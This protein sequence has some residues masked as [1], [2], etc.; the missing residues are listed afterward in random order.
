MSARCRTSSA[1]FTVLEIIVSMILLGVVL[2][3]VA[4]LTKRV[5]DQRRA[6]EARR[7]ALFEVSNDLERLVADRSAWP[8]AGEQ[9]S[10]D[11]SA[12]LRTRFH[13]PEV[14]I[15]RIT[16]TDPTGERFDASF[17]WKEPNG[18]R[19]APVTLSAFSFDTNA[20]DAP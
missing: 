20:G 14:T 4:P 9:K 1:G 10:L 16:L 8:N 12:S 6:N 11:I 7:A 2:S 3:M 15:R 5:V 19:A 18:R 17:S 13:E